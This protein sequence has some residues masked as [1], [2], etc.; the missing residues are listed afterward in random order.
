[1]SFIPVAQ[2][3]LGNARVLKKDKSNIR[4]YV[5]TYWYLPTYVLYFFLLKYDLDTYLCT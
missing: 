5:A 4:T 2:N 1:M 3:S